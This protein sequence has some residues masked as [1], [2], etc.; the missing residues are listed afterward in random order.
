MDELSD[1]EHIRQRPSMYIGATNQFGI[2]VLA[3]EAVDNA[4]D[5]FLAG[6]ATRVDVQLDGQTMR[7]KDNG[8]GYPFDRLDEN[9]DSVGEKYFTQIHKQNTAD[10]H[11]PH[12]HANGFG[13]GL[14]ALCALTQRLKI[15]SVRRGKQY[16][17]EYSRGVAQSSLTSL[18]SN[19]P[20]GTEIEFELDE[21]IFNDQ[22]V[23]QQLLS[24]KLRR[25]SFLFPG[26]SVG[27]QGEVY[28]P[29][30]GLIDLIKY[31]M[32]IDEA[33]A[34]SF[35]VRANGTIISAA[36]MGNIVEGNTQQKTQVFSFANAVP[37]FEESS[38]VIGL[39]RAL[40]R[41]KWRPAAAAISVILSDPRYAGPT[42]QV[43]DVPGLEKKISDILAV[44]IRQFRET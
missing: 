5:Q 6:K 34:F 9:G 22:L 44:S 7:V 31:E 24:A 13:A 15:T 2:Q 1:L 21:Q 14:F 17:Q 18:D 12:V 26:L 37:T 40:Q 11:V 20:S 30:A 29:T 27:F 41:T 4:L 10:D 42:R 3:F 35:S 36:A 16:C 32:S 38:H 33:P 39:K 43:L 28:G 25:Q 19:E 8:E 23:D